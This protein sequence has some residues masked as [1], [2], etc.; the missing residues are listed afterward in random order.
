[1]QAKYLTRDT[2]YLLYSLKLKITSKLNDKLKLKYIFKVNHSS[3]NIHI[4]NHDL[5]FA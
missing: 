5:I 4:I 3:Y 2:R 1:M